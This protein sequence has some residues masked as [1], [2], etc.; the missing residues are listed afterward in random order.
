[1]ATRYAYTLFDLHKQGANSMS[2]EL[3]HQLEVDPSEHGLEVLAGRLTCWAVEVLRDF[4]P[5]IGIYSA[6]LS[7]ID[8]DGEP[9]KYVYS[10]HLCWNGSDQ[11]TSWPDPRRFVPV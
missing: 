11:I 10:V 3:V 1:M 5:G 8:E 7:T 4:E 9:D 6:E 2:Y